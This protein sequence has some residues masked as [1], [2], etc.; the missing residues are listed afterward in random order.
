MVQPKSMANPLDTMMV[1]KGP[2]I[3]MPQCEPKFVPTIQI[4][5]LENIKI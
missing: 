4:Y 5:I 1:L 3:I 2:P